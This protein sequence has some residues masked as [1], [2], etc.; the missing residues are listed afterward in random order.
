V[1]AL[2]GPPPHSSHPQK[3]F[4]LKRKNKKRKE[5]GECQTLL[6]DSS[7]FLDFWGYLAK[8]EF[9]KMESTTSSIG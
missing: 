3:V 6:K 9:Q 5:V 4:F 8:S 7:P 1:Y 2:F